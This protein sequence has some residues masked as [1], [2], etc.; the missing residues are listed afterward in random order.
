MCKEYGAKIPQQRCERLTKIIQKKFKLL[1]LKVV[2]QALNNGVYLVFHRT[3]IQ[4]S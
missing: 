2:L 4:M 3:V 1:L